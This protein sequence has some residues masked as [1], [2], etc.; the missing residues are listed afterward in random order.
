MNT[1]LVIGGAGYIGT[2]CVYELIEQGYQVVI[3]DN[4]STGHQE[5]IHPQAHF[6]QGD[7]RDLDF[8]NQVMKQYPIDAIMHF[9]ADSLVGVS[10]KDPLTY[11]NNNVYGMNVL[12]EAMK[13]NAINH[14]VFSSS[15]GV[16]GEPSQ[17]PV[18]ESLPMQPTSPYGETKRIMETMMQWCDNAYGIKYVALRYFNACGAHPN[19]LIGELHEPETHLIPLVI[20]SI[21]NKQQLVINGSDY[22]TKDG[23]CIRDYIHVCDLARAHIAALDYLEQTQTSNYFNLGSGIGYSNL[24]IIRSVEAATG[25]PVQFSFG[26]RRAGDP[27]TLYAN[28]KKAEELLHF[29]LEYTDLVKMIKTAYQFYLNR[30]N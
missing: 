8:L 22:P 13:Q 19:G 4:L 1:I 27:A 26:P 6:H 14:I 9:A 16:Y 24:E 17:T 2:H 15:A 7:I 12:L 23:T 11:Y 20:K 10:V 30:A 3:I 28:N 29:K 21:M 25:K 18:V 5:L